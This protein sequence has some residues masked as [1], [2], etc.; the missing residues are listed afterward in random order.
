MSYPKFFKCKGDDTRFCVFLN[1]DFGQEYVFEGK[2]KCVADEIDMWVI[3]YLNAKEVKDT[4][5]RKIYLRIYN[6]V[7]EDMNR[8]I[9][10]YELDD[11]LG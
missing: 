5:L 3:R 6:A 4:T 9:D 10:P 11:F 7:Q 2:W 8:P 1:A